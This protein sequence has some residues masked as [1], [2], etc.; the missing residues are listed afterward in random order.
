MGLCDIFPR[1]FL[2]GYT[3]DENTG[4]TVLWPKPG[5]VY[6]CCV[7]VIVDGGHLASFVVNTL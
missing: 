2:V 7:N 3:R 4:F 1:I 6:S 5:G